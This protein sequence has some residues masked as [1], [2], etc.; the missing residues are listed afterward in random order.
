MYKKGFSV[1]ALIFL[2]CTPVF[3]EQGCY[4]IVAGKGATADGSVLVGHNED[5]ARRYAAG[6]WKVERMNHQGRRMGCV[7]LRQSYSTGKNNLWL[8]VAANA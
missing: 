3:G 7:H 5:N 8:L 2:I 4:S 1:G 6:M